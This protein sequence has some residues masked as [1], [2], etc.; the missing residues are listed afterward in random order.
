MEDLAFWIGFGIGAVIWFVW[1]VVM[2]PPEPGP[3]SKKSHDP[4]LALLVLWI[5]FEWFKEEDDDPC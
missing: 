5:G 2:G 1:D 3:S 4:W